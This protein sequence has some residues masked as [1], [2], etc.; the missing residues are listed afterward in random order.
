M[1]RWIV[2]AAL[3][4]VAAGCGK[5]KAPASATAEAPLQHYKMTGVVVRLDPGN[6]LATIKHE[7]IKDD[8]GKVW[9]EA[10]TMD[11]PVRDAQEF[12]KLKVDQAIDARV[13]QKPSDF[14]FW[15]DQITPKESTGGGTPAGK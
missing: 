3:L 2:L 12:A 11:F 10:M 13:N 4:L 5:E 14:D 9:M 15:L 8:A 6:K 1:V 7:V